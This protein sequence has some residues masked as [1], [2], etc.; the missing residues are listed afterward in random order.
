M[1]YLRP[2]L[3][4]N[5]FSIA[6]ER[7]IIELHEVFGNRWSQI[8]SQLPGRTDNQI[9][10]FWNSC[11][12]KR[13]GSLASKVYSSRAEGKKLTDDGINCFNNFSQRPPIRSIF[14][15][16]LQQQNLEVV[17]NPPEIQESNAWPVTA[18]ES[19]ALTRRTSLPH[20]INRQL[21]NLMDA[22]R[23]SEKLYSNVSA[24]QSHKLESDP[25]QV[26]PETDQ[27]CRFPA[28]TS[29]SSSIASFPLENSSLNSV[30][31]SNDVC[32]PNDQLMTSPIIATSTTVA[33]FLCSEENDL[34]ATS[35]FPHFVDLGGY[36]TG[37]SN[38]NYQA[39]V[40]LNNGAQDKSSSCDY[41]DPLPKSSF[42]GS[43]AEHLERLCDVPS[44]NSVE[45]VPFTCKYSNS[46]NDSDFSGSYI[47]K[48]EKHC[49]SKTTTSTLA[50]TNSSSSDNFV[51]TSNPWL[52]P[53]FQLVFSG[54]EDC[55][56]TK[57]E[58]ADYHWLSDTETLKLCSLLPLSCFTQNL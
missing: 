37:V 12:K 4:L 38:H 28:A 9:K 18:D 30:S 47:T 41:A 6:E 21:Q 35:D 31:S 58:P 5:S 36:F 33:P 40:L 44:C 27:F 22:D 10:N 54:S 23:S 57:S 24:Y 3:N 55:L 1:N 25:H 32:A 50:D 52:D 39:V 29:L 48:P 26:L 13:I 20:D 17:G 2:D 16:S 14:G 45:E 56:N 34:V 53:A 7:R 51:T 49:N 43:Y 46:L 11:I 15:S 8:A 19:M 42:L